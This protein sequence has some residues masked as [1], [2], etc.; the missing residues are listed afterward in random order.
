MM[1]VDTFFKRRVTFGNMAAVRTISFLAV[2][3]MA[4]SDEP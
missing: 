2:G 3:V 4:I 1:F